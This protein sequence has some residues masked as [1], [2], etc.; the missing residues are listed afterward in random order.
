MREQFIDWKPRSQR[1]NLL[2]IANKI[3][4]D[5]DEKG[6]VLTL[7]QLYYQMVSK[8]IIPNTIE[9]YRHLGKIISKG[10]L[11]GF[12]DWEMM[13]DRIRVIKQNS[14]WD[15]PSDILEMAADQYYKDRWVH[16]NQYIEIWIEKDALTG[17]VEPVCSKY[18][19]K[20]LANKG[21]S[22]SSALYVASKRFINAR[23]RN[24]EYT[25]IY[26][27]DH[28][29]SGL[30]MVRD[31]QERMAL[32]TND[33]DFPV[34]QIALTM[35]QI[36]KY[37]PPENPAKVTDTRFMNYRKEYGSNSWELDALEPSVLTDIVKKAIDKYID[38]E[39]FN[40]VSKEEADEKETLLNFIGLL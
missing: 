31:I 37:N 30:D 11:A 24:K 1:M 8:D 7:R 26:L 21:Y 19:V 34:V 39:E 3:L 38:W 6:Y 35:E 40:R 27:G 23:N 15:S 25:L 20:F 36:R 13:E 32:F 2:S 22:S 17:I 16:Q 18:D 14:H 28:D 33:L 10:R 9:E 29:P 12:L 5:M 4:C